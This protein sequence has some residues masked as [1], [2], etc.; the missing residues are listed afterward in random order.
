CAKVHRPLIDGSGHLLHQLQ[1]ARH[2]AVV[3]LDLA[4][5]VLQAAVL[6]CCACDECLMAKVF[7][8]G[9]TS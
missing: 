3:F 4:E 8:L 6:S 7:R 5:R 1:G 9:T 2:F